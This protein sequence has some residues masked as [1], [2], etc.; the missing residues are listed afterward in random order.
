LK[1]LLLCAAMT[2]LAGPARSAEAGAER[3]ALQRLDALLAEAEAAERE[4][5]PF[6]DG[7]RARIQE[8]ASGKP[9]D[10][11]AAFVEQVAAD[12][13]AA[14]G[15]ERL[16]ELAKEWKG[17]YKEPMLGYLACRALAAGSPEPCRSDPAY[18]RKPKDSDDTPAHTCLEIYHL[19]RFMDARAG[20]TDAVA[21]CRAAYASLVDPADVAKGGGAPAVTAVCSEA[22]RGSCGSVEKLPW[23][24]QDRALC[25]AFMGAAQGASRSC[26]KA[27]N[28]E[29]TLG[30]RCGDVAALH[31]ARK[32][33]SCGGSALCAAAVERGPGPSEAL[34]AKTRDSYCGDLARK[35]EAKEGPALPKDAAKSPGARAAAMEEVKARH[36]LIDERMRALDAALEAYTPRSEPGLAARVSRGRDIR[37]RV[38]AAFHSFKSVSEGAGASGPR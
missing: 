31:A 2:A 36:R 27:H 23:F 3:P 9:V 26:A 15:L 34:L 35:R 17:H 5:G 33:G 21:E 8:G 37:R 29:F 38:D 7:A 25:E 12:C 24:V 16:P 32:G 1:T 30:V 28:D 6:L 14:F 11:N 18:R 20:G 13:R 19:M 22:A 4:L 10:R